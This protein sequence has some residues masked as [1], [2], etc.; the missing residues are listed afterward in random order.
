MTPLQAEQFLGAAC[1]GEWVGGWE[2]R[3]R[4]GKGSVIGGREG[5]GWA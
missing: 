2:A 3:A 4:M 5:V 1:Q